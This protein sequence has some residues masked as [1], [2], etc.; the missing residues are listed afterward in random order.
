MLALPICYELPSPIVMLSTIISLLLV[1][2]RQQS[3]VKNVLDVHTSTVKTTGGFICISLGYFH[4]D[5]IA[6]S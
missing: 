3:C 6:P 5:K 1:T 4:I 2:T